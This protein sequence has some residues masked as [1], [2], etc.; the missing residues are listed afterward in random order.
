MT[1]ATAESSKS[2]PTSHAAKIALGDA[3]ARAVQALVAK[4]G[5][6]NRAAIEAGVERVAARWSAAD[7]DAAAFES[8]CAK[9]FVADPAERTRLLARVE[10]ALEQITGHLYEMRRTLRR[11]HDLRGD[12]FDGVDDIL[13]QFDPSPDLSEQLY[14][15]KLAH[16]ALL[17]LARPKLDEM[18][19]DGPSWSVDQWVAA[20]VAQQFGPRIPA[21]LADRAR[22]NS[23]EAGK[24]VADFHVPVGGVVDANGKR[25]FEADRKLIAHWLV[26]EEIK[27]GYGD[28]DGV[29]K[30]RALSW[31]MARHIDGTIPVRVMKGDETRDW[32]PEKNTVAGG[33]PGE[34]FGLARYEHWI[35]NFRMAQE[36][37]PLFP[38]EPTAIARKFALEREMPE[39]E[40]EKLMIDL[41]ESPVRKEIAAFMAKKL[42]RRLEPY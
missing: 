20:R 15:Q 33:D 34:L 36:F 39:S 2:A 1:P 27:A 16:L 38:D 24:F 18:L 25:W 11:H 12:E 9:H 13:A 10:G 40:V 30:Q 29:H 42:G 8:F 4:Y 35:K 7:G 6:G 28:A 41:L 26:R 21:E 5:E 23:F 14:R 31:V 19:R 37:D 22:K 3:S 17:N 32:N